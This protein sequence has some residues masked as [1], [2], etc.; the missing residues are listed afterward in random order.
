[1]ID[2]RKALVS[3]FL[4][5]RERFTGEGGLINGDIDC[6]EETT[7]CRNDIS[8]FE[9]NHIP[10]DQEGGLD[11]QPL[12]ITFALG[13]RCERVHQRSNRVTSVPFLVE[14]DGRVDE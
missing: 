3:Y 4:V 7:I 10:R 5:L 2:S 11:L 8:N 1:M 9:S 14:P 12:T 13:L 6:F